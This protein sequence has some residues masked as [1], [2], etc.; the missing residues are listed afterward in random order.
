MPEKTN[1]TLQ[2]VLA[3]LRMMIPLILVMLGALIFAGRYEPANAL[4]NGEITG[5][6]LMLFGLI[7]LLMVKIWTIVEQLDEKSEE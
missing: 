3:L 5:V 6:I 2:I 4:T 1:E 7:M